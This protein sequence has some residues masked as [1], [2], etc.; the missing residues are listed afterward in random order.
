ML[1]ETPKRSSASVLSPSVT[2]TLRML[3]PNRASRSSCVADQ[4]A[5]ARTQ[6]PILAVTAGLETCP[7]TVLRATPSRDWMY[8]NS[9][10]P[11]AAWLRF[12]KSMSIVAQGSSTFAWVCRCSSGVRSASRPAIHIL[13][14]ENV[15]I[16]AIT[17][18][19]ASSALASSAIRRIASELLSTGFQMI[20]TGTCSAAPIARAIWRD[21]SA[22]WASVSAPYRS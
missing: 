10:S 4:P 15:C 2:A 14:G 11:C 16:H 1:T 17:P 21:C 22:T 9:R 13:A 12:M 18:M 7:T 6:D 3:S 19:Q 8:P 20:L 5:A